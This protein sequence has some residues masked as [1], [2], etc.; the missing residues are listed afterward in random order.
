MSPSRFAASEAA[1]RDRW[2]KA[3]K[4][5]FLLGRAAGI[6]KEHTRKR[7]RARLA[8]LEA[9]ARDNDQLFETFITALGQAYD[10]HT[11]YLSDRTLDR[12]RN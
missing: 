7:L 6:D 12:F 11:S 5:E 9:A 2:R 4:Y 3:V 1:L 10:P 8:R